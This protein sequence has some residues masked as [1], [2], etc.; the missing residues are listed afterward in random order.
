M[1][2]FSAEEKGDFMSSR[3]PSSISPTNPFRPKFDLHRTME[4]FANAKL[5][6]I[7]IAGFIGFCWLVVH[8]VRLECGF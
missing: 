1:I 3:R 5:I 6:V 8:V 4:F 7:E 2:F